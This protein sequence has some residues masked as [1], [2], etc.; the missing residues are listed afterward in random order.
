MLVLP[1]I[2]CISFYAITDID[3]PRRGLIRVHPQNLLS[4]AKSLQ[5][6]NGQDQFRLVAFGYLLVRLIGHIKNNRTSAVTA[7][8]GT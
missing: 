7:L 4:L 2:L 5:G 8:I 6:H 3:S 1:L